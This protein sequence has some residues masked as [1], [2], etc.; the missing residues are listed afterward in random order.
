MKSVGETMAVG[1]S[2]QESFQKA[3]RSLEIGLTGLNPVAMPEV[4]DGGNMQ[5][6][7]AGWLGERVPERLR[8][9]VTAFAH[10]Y[11]IEDVAAYTNWLNLNKILHCKVYRMT[12]QC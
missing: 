4:G 6:V 1:R 8:R 7:I 5:D 10:G 2:F 9:I 3:L 12:Q 11:S